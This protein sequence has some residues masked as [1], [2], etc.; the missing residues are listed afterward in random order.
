MGHK[1]ELSPEQVDLKVSPLVASLKRTW[2]DFCATSSIHGLRY[3]RDEDTNR[4]V[5]FVWLLISLVMFICA[6]V[7]ARTFYIDFRS[8]PTR[9]NVE[10][11]NTP[12]SNLYFPPVTICPDVLFNMQKSEAFL[13][14]LQLPQGTNQS[15]ILRKLHIFYGFMLDDEKYSD[16]DINPMESLLSLNNL[17][18]QQLVEHLRWNCDEILYR[19]RFNGQ[20]RDCLE[21]FQLSKTFFGH[22]C[23]FNLRQTGLNFTGERAV[24]GLKYGLSVILRYKDD[25]YD[26]VQ[27]YSFGVKLLIQ[28]ADAF[29]SAHSSSKFIA[30]DSE[31]FAALHPQETFCSPAVKALSIEDRNCVFRN[32]FTMRYFKNYV[33]PNCELNCRVTNMVKFCNC[34][35]Y[36]FD[37]NRTTDRICTFKDIPCLVDNFAN[38]IT[39]KRSTQCYCPLTCEHLDYDVQISDFPLKLNMPVADQ[40]YSGIAKNDGILHVFINSFGYRRLRHDLL[41]NMVTLVSNLGSAFSLFVGMSMLSVVEIIYYFSVILRK[42]YVLEC[43]ARK[44]MLHK[45]PK[46]AWPK[47]NDSYS[48]HEKS[49]FIIHKS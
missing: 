1:E 23:S 25:N 34:H 11:D 9:M 3:T 31:V 16:Q 13:K 18:L 7:M 37:F 14:T 19:C 29:P 20:I 38:I 12:V 40:F 47:A 28:E 22:C 2:N 33:Y 15:F 21:L 27:S 43:E 26:P 10:S 35:T 5:H 48:K 4:I 6:V 30:F 39:R 32:E 45:G 44:K 49:V 17:T 46:F 41:S 8:N 24:G 42:N 36:F